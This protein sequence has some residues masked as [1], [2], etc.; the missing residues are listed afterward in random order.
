[1]AFVLLLALATAPVETPPPPEVPR[2]Q[3]LRWDPR[4]DLPIT[5]TLI[6]AWVLSETALKSTLA[7]ATCRW[8]ETNAFDNAF[9]GLFNPAFSPSASGISAPA[10][11][12]DVLAYGVVPAMAIGLDLLLALDTTDDGW[13][14]RW[15]I[16]VALMAEATISAM[17]VNQF[18]K[19]TVGRARPYT[20]GASEELL[21]EH[22]TNDHYVSFFSGHA[23]FTFAIAT[24]AATVAT[25]RRYKYAW[26][27]WVVGI[28]LATAVSVLRVAADK[29]W[30]S[31]VLVGSLFGSAVG[32]LMPTLL[33][34]RVG[35]VELQASPMPNG[36]TVSGRF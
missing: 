20:I 1:M 13:W 32:V 16:D 12:S 28:P 19:F 31:E 8:C 7:P 35:P 5:G 34:G 14:K 18:V 21:A 11:V 23:T 29:H 33:H 25:L 30:T 10:R 26:V 15:L 2:V 22:N 17:V 9:R 36:V 3:E 6:V 4:V 24:S 27:T